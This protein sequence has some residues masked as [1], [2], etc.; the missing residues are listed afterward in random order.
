MSDDVSARVAIGEVVSRYSFYYDER[1][2]DEVAEL[3]EPDAVF[4]FDSA[5]GAVGSQLNGRDEIRRTLAERSAA[6][7]Q[8][9]R[10]HIVTNTFV[11]VLDNDSASAITYI[12]LA[13]T[14]NGQIAILAS[15]VY[16]DRFARSD[17]GWRFAERRLRLDSKLA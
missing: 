7:P 1:R 10:R 9:Q 12:L 11:E 16:R 14:E 13:S 2:F 6:M 17:G 5:I 15:G 3:F 4:V 8:V